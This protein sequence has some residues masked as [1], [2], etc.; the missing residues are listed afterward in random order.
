M[1]LASDFAFEIPV[2][3]LAVTVGTYDVAYIFWNLQPDPWMTQ[4]TFSA[5][6]GDPV[7]VYDSGLSHILHVWLPRQVSLLYDQ[8]EH[9]GQA[10]L[11]RLCVAAV[12]AGLIAIIAGRP[13]VHES[14]AKVFKNAVDGDVQVRGGRDVPGAIHDS[15]IRAVAFDR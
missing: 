2:D 11:V 12:G 4:C 13:Q 7:A 5:I 14:H 10:L 9:L 6:T 8:T 3:V 1:C 15:L